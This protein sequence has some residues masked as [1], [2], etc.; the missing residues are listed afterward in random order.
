MTCVTGVSGA[1]K[2]TLVMEVLY[3][4]INRAAARGDEIRRCAD[5]RLGKLDR[6]IA[7]NQ[8]SI[9]RTPRSNAAPCRPL[10][11][12]ARFLPNCRKPACGVTRRSAVQPQRWTLRPGGD[13]VT[14]VEMHFLPEMF[15]TCEV[16]RGRRYNRETPRLV[17]GLSIADVL[18]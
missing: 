7:V 12:P 14:R 15:V 13:G 3:H 10:R 16:C 9:G 8:S 2:S 11:S 1:G 17:L 18:I 6:L 4:G 5:H